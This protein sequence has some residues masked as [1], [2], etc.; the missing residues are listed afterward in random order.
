LPDWTPNQNLVPKSADEMEKREQSQTGCRMFR[1]TF[2]RARPLHATVE[3]KQKFFFFFVFKNIK[4]KETKNWTLSSKEDLVHRN[5]ENVFRPKKGRHF[6]WPIF[7]FNLWP[8]HLLKEK[9]LLYS[10]RKKEI[11]FS[12]PTG[13]YVGRIWPE[14]TEI[15]K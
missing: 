11:P 10:K 8:S 2:G 5:K 6:L 14:E 4:W 7:V 13:N 9:N 3:T 15:R 12:K 1:R